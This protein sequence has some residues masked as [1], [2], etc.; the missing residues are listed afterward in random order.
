M[1]S[2]QLPAGAILVDAQTVSGVN[3]STK[4]LPTPTA[5]EADDK[6]SLNRA[7]DRDRRGPLGLDG[8]DRLTETGKRLMYDQDQRWELIGRNLIVPQVA[9]DDPLHKLNR[10]RLI[11]HPGSPRH[12]PE[13][14]HIQRASVFSSGLRRQRP[15]PAGGSSQ[16]WSGARCRWAPMAV[17]R[18][19]RPRPASRR[20]RDRARIFR[21]YFPIVTSLIVSIVASLIFWLIRR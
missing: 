18:Q 5:V 11:G 1:L 16:N 12:G 3:V 8:L 17:A 21:F 9:G 4:H 19:S 2:W 6:I 14:Y 15:W 10:A 20:H 13:P 7:S